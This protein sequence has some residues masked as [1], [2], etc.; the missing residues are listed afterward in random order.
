MSTV[1]F[2]TVEYYERELTYYLSNMNMSTSMK[3]DATKKILI[4]LETE[5][6]NVFLFDETIRIK[7][8]HNLLKAFGKMLEKS[9]VTS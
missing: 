5:I 7:C 1:L 4:M 8:F 3:E 9:L 6:F 2:G